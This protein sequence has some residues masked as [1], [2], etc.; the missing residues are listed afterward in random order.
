MIKDCEDE[1]RGITIPVTT[2]TTVPTTTPT[3]IS[4]S[5]LNGTAWSATTQ[6]PGGEDSWWW[7]LLVTGAIVLA[8]GVGFVLYSK[9]CRGNGNGNP[10]E[11]QDL[12]EVSVTTPGGNDENR[13]SLRG[14]L[15]GGGGGSKGN[16][17]RHN[18]NND[19][20][21]IKLLQR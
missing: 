13:Q 18:Q 1:N 17:Q 8:A 15:K 7:P 9:Y 20:S 6:G 5:I 21:K 19:K 16:D 2:T 3:T 14:T 10:E 12:N 11:N 4:S